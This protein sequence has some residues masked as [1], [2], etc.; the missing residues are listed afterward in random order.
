[1]ACGCSMGLSSTPRKYIKESYHH[2]RN[3]NN[4][5]QCNNYITGS[6]IVSIVILS[7][8]FVYLSYQLYSKSY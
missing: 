5:N 4:N 3:N 2:N 1:M 7:I 8:L 6:N